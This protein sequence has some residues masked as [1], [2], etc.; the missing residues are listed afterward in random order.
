MSEVNPNNS[1]LESQPKQDQKKRWCF[2]WL[3]KHPAA[4]GNERAYLLNQYKWPQGENITVSFLDGDSRL[5]KKVK[6]IALEWVWPGRANLSFQFKNH[7][8]T[9]IRISFKEEGSWSVLGKSCR[10][11]TDTRTPTMNFG[12]LTPETDDDEVRRVVLHEFGH[13]L[14]LT[15]EHMNPH[16]SP[17]KWNRPQV[18]ADLSGSPNNWSLADIEANMFQTFAE[19]ETNYTDFDPTSIMIYPIPASWTLDG[20]SINLNN[21]I[22][23]TDEDFIAEQYP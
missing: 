6:N 13:A 8:N 9:D 3:A 17:I 2:S 20:S 14:G 11:I 19:N 23:Q 1:S 15:H 5:Q 18:I 4:T 10:E 22:S 16:G 7:T 21:D 12:W